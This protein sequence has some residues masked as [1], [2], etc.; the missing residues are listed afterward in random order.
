MK[1]FETN[2]NNAERALRFILAIFLIPTPLILEP[3]L[4]SFILSSVGLILL[5]MVASK[6]T[7]GRNRF[8]NYPLR[9][10]KNS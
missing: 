4:Y 7:E 10:K 9:L 8:G 2:Q 3:S 1:I 5:F 6:G